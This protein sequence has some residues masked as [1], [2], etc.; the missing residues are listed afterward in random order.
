[1]TQDLELRLDPSIAY[2]PMRLTAHVSTQLGIDANRVHD[3]KIHRRSIVAGSSV[4]TAL[5]AGRV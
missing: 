5:Y 3:V 1:M 2:T 4:T